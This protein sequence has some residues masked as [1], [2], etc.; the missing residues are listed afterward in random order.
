MHSRSP[1][2]T[3][4]YELST[5]LAQGKTLAKQ[6]ARHTAS[7]RFAR[8][9]ALQPGHVESLLW[10]AAL[11]PEPEESI[12]Y[13]NRVLQVSPGHPGALAG[14]EWARE[15]RLALP[16]KPPPSPARESLALTD[17][18]LL[19]SIVFASLVAC[20]ILTAMAWGAPE[21][22][23]AAYQPTSTFAIFSMAT[24]LAASTPTHTPAPT[25][26]VIAAAT[27]T[28]A[29]PAATSTRVVP[30]EPPSA[31]LL[32][33][34]WIELDLSDQMLTAYEGQTPVFSALVSTGVPGLPTPQGEY[35]I[36]RKVRS[37]VMSGSGYYL[38][39]VEYVSYFYKGYAIH[40]T[41][42]HNNFGHPMS[43]G[44]VNM[45]NG[46]ARWIYEWAPRGTRVIVRA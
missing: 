11:S 14:I 27:P 22:V 23:R 35:T 10:L 32:G 42:W 37:Q 12:R 45:T 17:K 8:V 3:P 18:L 2:P 36:Y 1:H 5:L 34:K 41:Y 29:P 46:D 44:C 26:T 21:A 25:A 43:H 24:T 6:G 13:L 33:T 31:T 19:S 38:P 15:R 30:G 9:L 28:S 20:M 40:G 4:A 39:N 7:T 16:A